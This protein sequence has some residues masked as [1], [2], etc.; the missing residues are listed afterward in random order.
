MARSELIHKYLSDLE[1][2]LSRVSQARAQEVV[3]EIESH[4]YDALA[5]QDESG[6]SG[7]EAILGR[8]GTPRELAAAYID[9]ITIGAAPPK[10]FKPL[11]RVTKGISKGLYWMICGLGYGAGFALVALA[12]LMA[13]MPGTIGVW[14]SEHGN[15]V[16]ISFREL[17]PHGR[18]LSALWLVPSS[19]ALGGALLYL[20]ARVARI[21]KLHTWRFE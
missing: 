21:L 6:E 13:L 15:S 12:L 11:S 2:S 14:V 4:I 1:T 8:L 20:T 3:Q 18:A 7:V 16:V 9:H 10:G 19:I 17:A 5:M